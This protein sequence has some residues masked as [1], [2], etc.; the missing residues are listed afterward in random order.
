[1]N[2]IIRFIPNLFTLGNVGMGLL[3]IVLIAKEEM[4]LAIYCVA[5]AL[6]LDFIDG[7]AA[8]LLRAQSKLGGELDSL[9]DMVTFGLLPGFILFQMISIGRGIYF[10]E[11]SRWTTMDFLNCSVAMLVPMA[12]AY[13]LAVYNLDETARPHFLGLPTPAMC[14]TVIGIPL[15]L[16]AHYK[17][18][19]YYLLSDGFI[20]INGRERRWDPSDFMVVK[21]MF[22]PLFYQ[23]SSVVLAA[24]MVVKIPMLSLK[25]S[26]LSWRLNK[27]RYSLIIWA[28]ISYL[29]FLLPYTRI[30][31]IDIGLID[32]LILPIFMA[33]YFVLSWIYAIFGAS[34]SD[35]K[36]NEIQ[37]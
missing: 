29:I 1:M 19:F 20:D 5:V 15:V 23:I 12:A 37:S 33:G 11:I 18:N 13:R 3:G 30:S 2:S 22:E 27:W 21:M 10:V 17:L 8:R 16:E 6:V 34:N 31:F 28:V 35:I 32:F 24:M 7:F 9:A 36:T 25:F 14:I 26:G 4:V